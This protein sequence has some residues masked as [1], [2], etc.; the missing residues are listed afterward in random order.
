MQ[1][2]KGFTDT[3]ASYPKFPSVKDLVFLRTI[4]SWQ[5]ASGLVGLL[6]N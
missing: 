3:I 5:L 4:N 1:K 6:N 2:H